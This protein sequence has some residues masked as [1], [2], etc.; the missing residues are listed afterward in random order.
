MSILLV[1]CTG[2]L[3]KALI[4]RL[5]KKT[6]YKLLVAIRSKKGISPSS[7][8]KS[9]LDEL[10]I[11]SRERITY[12]HVSYD[13]PR[14]IT[15]KRRDREKIRNEVIILINAL[16][17]IST[18]N[19]LNKAIQYNTLIALNWLSIFQQCANPQKYIYISSA[20]V[21]FHRRGRI[22]EQ[23]Y[24]L[25]NE[26]RC[27]RRILDG[28]D[29]DIAPY[30]N[31][32]I[33]SK[34]LTE[35]LLIGRAK[36]ISLAILR[37]S[38]LSP[39]IQRP[40]CGWGDFGQLQFVFLAIALGMI[41]SWNI[42]RKDILSNTIHLV[43][44]DIAAKDC[45]SLMNEKTALCI[46]HCCFTGNN[47]HAITYFTFYSYTLEAYRYFEKYPLYVNMK[48]MLPYYPKHTY[49]T[50]LSY[51]TFFVCAF[52]KNLYKNSHN[53]LHFVRLLQLSVK[54]THI[55]NAHLPYFVSKTNVFNRENKE[56][57][58]YKKY[59]QDNSYR[60]FIKNIPETLKKNRKLIDLLR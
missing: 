8:L 39:A 2:F 24:D 57:W 45:V 50:P 11:S 22:L 33:Y 18:Y 15:M 5:I 21:N 19:S 38:F 6:K 28:E 54:Y 40:Y 59:P 35:K 10:E 58:F 43:P 53:I 16:A 42:P 56:R 26:E 30:H 46:R 41:P 44:V 48:K 20:F 17:D 29:I 14:Q 37:P 1:G 27:L 13:K 34:Q 60:V 52:L 55:M 31:P 23:I 12:I 9:I 47:I 7:R 36:C 49:N 3:G 32:Y 25:N 4:Y 51:R